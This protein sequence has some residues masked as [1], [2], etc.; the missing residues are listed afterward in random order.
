MAEGPLHYNL[1]YFLA[2]RVPEEA[3]ALI[4]PSHVV[5]AVWADKLCCWGMISTK[6]L[7]CGRDDPVDLF[8]GLWS[9]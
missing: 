2:Y 5:E 1:P 7:T 8:T 4:T 6:K 3:S 9:A